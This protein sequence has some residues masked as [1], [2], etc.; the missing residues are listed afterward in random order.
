MM[1]NINKKVDITSSDKMEKNQVN[2]IPEDEKKDP[3]A[4]RRRG[5]FLHNLTA[6]SVEPANGR[7][8]HRFG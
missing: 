3:D 8:Y 1:S 5:L 4:E 7:R 2:S 6:E